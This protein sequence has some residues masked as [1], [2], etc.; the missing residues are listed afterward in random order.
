EKG[1]VV[2]DVGAFIGGFTLA[3]LDKAKRIIAV[4]PDP[5]NYLLLSYNTKEA[6]NVTII[7][8]AAYDFNSSLLLYQVD[9]PTSSS[10]LKPT[11]KIK[12]Q[13]TIEASRIDALMLEL[14]V[15][16]IDFLRID[17]EGAEPEVLEGTPLCRVKKVAVD[18]SPERFGKT[19]VFE[20]LKILLS[21]GFKCQ[22]RD[23]M[24]YAYNY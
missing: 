23:Y 2:F 7:K 1:D 5:F 13:I 14:G 16:K 11:T 17:A 9:D 18:C 20:V 22:V 21:A 10:L 15:E 3:I 12:K 4:E 19:T 8:K 24:V 6:G